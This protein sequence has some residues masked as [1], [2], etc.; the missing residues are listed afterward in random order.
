LSLQSDLIQPRSS[1]EA[2]IHFASFCHWGGWSQSEK[3][4]W[5]S[6]FDDLYHGQALVMLNK[7][8]ENWANFLAK[9][10]ALGSLPQAANFFCWLSSKKLDIGQPGADLAPG[11]E[12]WECT[13]GTWRWHQRR[14]K[15]ERLQS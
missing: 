14:R 6:D 8:A 3:P 1:G 13:W 2:A 7:N 15:D 9:T 11:V 10:S 12:L 4:Q 5:T